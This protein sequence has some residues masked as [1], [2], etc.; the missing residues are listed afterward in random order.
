MVYAILETLVQQLIENKHQLHTM[1]M[2]TILHRQFLN[3]FLNFGQHLQQYQH[4]H[5]LFIIQLKANV[6][7]LQHLAFNLNSMMIYQ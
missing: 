4:M 7:Q 6:Y 5:D 2:L 3:H 1:A